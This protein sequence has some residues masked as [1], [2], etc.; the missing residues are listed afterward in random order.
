MSNMVGFR[1]DY[2]EDFYIIDSEFLSG[3]R[4]LTPS[5]V[6][7]DISSP[8]LMRSSM[9]Q[10]ISRMTSL[11]SPNATFASA[12]MS[13]FEQT[14]SRHVSNVPLDLPARRSS[15]SATSTRPRPP[16]LTLSP[17]SPENRVRIVYGRGRVPT[18]VMDLSPVD[19]PSGNTLAAMSIKQSS[20][21]AFD[22]VGVGPVPLP[23]PTL[24]TAPLPCVTSQSPG[25]NPGPSPSKKER[26]TWDRGRFHSHLSPRRI[27]PR[28]TSAGIIRASI[29]PE[30]WG[31]FEA[32]L[33]TP[34]PQLV[35]SDSG[36]LG[37]GDPARRRRT[38]GASTSRF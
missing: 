16:P 20:M 25:L 17:T 19:L 12:V 18:L 26:I 3:T 38:T 22:D 13:D 32:L 14:P 24:R 5:G 21:D 15:S 34:A 35:R 11:V 30:R 4:K 36:V 6:R 7:I 33:Q 10:R 29:V 2:K 8:Q 31:N 28:P 37:E 9:A 1:L 27:T 23:S